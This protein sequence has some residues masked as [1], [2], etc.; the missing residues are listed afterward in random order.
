MTLPAFGGLVLA[1]LRRT[2]HAFGG[3]RVVAWCGANHLPCDVRTYIRDVD[4]AGFLL[5]R[6]V[7]S[8]G[9]TRFFLANKI[10]V[11]LQ[12]QKTKPNLIFYDDMGTFVRFNKKLKNVSCEYNRL[13]G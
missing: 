7:H 11:P 9:T 3:V 13:N 1:W 10:I 5:M 8:P 6:C 2:G 12:T 4:D